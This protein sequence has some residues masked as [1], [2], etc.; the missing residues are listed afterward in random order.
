MKKELRDL[1]P[2]ELTEAMAALG[3]PP[4]RGTQVFRWLN[5]GGIRSFSEMTDIPAGLKTAL[6]EQY[7]I[8]RLTLE[9]SM[10]SEDGTEKF[11]WRLDDGNYVESVLIREKERST[12]C[13]S[14]QVG[15]R[16]RCPFC[17][18][19]ADGFTRDLRV[20]EITG[21]FLEVR[22]TSGR[23]TNVVF[24]GMGEPLD[25]YDNLVKAIRIINHRDGGGIGARKITVSTCGIVPAIRRL[26]DLGLQVELSVSLH[27]ANNSLR[28]RLVP[29][30]RRY[31]LGALTDACLDY[32]E[33][34]GRV[35]TLEYTLLPGEN[36]SPR[37]AD[38]L[39]TIA[40]KIKAKVNLIACSACGRSGAAGKAAG[41]VRE[42]RDRLTAAGAKVTIRKSKGKDILAACGQLA[43]KKKKERC[44]TGS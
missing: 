13:L 44:D 35:I 22:A 20:S 24:M 26:K 17:A 30:N 6:E 7:S 42:F 27:A 38:N 28:D 41:Q 11:L 37:D 40:K 36:D 15:C 3:E 33:K 43:G 18:S 14:T 8:G 9:E 25:N 5:A 34:T 10:T 23:L 32:S 1:L 12:L 29:V 4:Y 2:E 31:P 19:G 21:Q 16:F 39:A